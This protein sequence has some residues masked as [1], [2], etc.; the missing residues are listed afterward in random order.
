MGREFDADVGDDGRPTANRTACTCAH[1]ALPRFAA[2]LV[3]ELDHIYDGVT[4]VF[5]VGLGR[6]SGRPRHYDTP[7]GSCAAVDPSAG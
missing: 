3:D 1:R 6:R 2:W 4:P 7:V 5:P